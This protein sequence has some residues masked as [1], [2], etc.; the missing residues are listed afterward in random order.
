MNNRQLLFMVVCLSSLCGCISVSL[1]INSPSEVSLQVLN[2][3]PTELEN[4]TFSPAN[5]SLVYNLPELPANTIKEL[6]INGDKATKWNISRFDGHRRL[7]AIQQNLPA[8]R[9]LVIFLPTKC[10]IATVNSQGQLQILQSIQLEPEL[11]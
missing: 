7:G 2:C 1:N 4:I 9:P 3:T 8:N 11:L 10:L 6:K 5:S